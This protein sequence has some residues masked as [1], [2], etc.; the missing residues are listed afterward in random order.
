MFGSWFS[1]WNWG[2][3]VF[4]AQLNPIVWLFSLLGIPARLLPALMLLIGCFSSYVLLSR[5]SRNVYAKTAGV[6]V[7]NINGFT[8]YYIWQGTYYG[9]LLAIALF[10]I[11]VASVEKAIETTTIRAAALSA[12]VCAVFI[13]SVALQETYVL[14]ALLSL[15]V[16]FRAFKVR[17]TQRMVALAAVVVFFS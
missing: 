17:S 4:T 7:Y 2:P 10:P 9:F 5:H 15:Y 8:A 16:L 3:Y 11:V 14:L 6:L 12:I 13:S 1:C